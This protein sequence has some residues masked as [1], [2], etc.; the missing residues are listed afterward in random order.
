MPSHITD[1]VS[2]TGMVGGGRFYTPVVATSV[3]VKP[4]P[5]RVFRVLGVAGTG[6]VSVYD[7]KLG[8]TSGTLLWTKAT[9]AV[10]DI[11]VIDIPTTT[12]IAVTAAAATTV[13]V[14]WS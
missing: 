10:G 8:N 12:G 13:N 3:N 11:Y 1:N 4:S 2:G 7:N 14:I 9:V 6:A 5:G